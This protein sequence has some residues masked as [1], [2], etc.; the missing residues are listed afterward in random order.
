MATDGS[1]KALDAVALAAQTL[2]SVLEP[3]AE[4]NPDGAKKSLLGEIEAT[5][6]KASMSTP[7]DQ[8]ELTMRSFNCL[9]QNGIN[10][11]PEL[12][13]LTLEELEQFKNL[14]KKSLNE[15]ISKLAERGL[16]FK[17]S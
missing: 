8:L 13:N 15:I 4:F 6:K 12:I 17:D 10:T 7:I 14:G 11:I 1:I 2:I 16:K 5:A 9:K 3:I